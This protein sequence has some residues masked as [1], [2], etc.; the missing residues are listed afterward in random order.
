MAVLETARGGLLKRGLAFDR[1]GVGVVLNVSGDHLGLDGVETL[2]DLAHVKGL[3]ARCAAS[4]AVLNAED[5]WCVAMNESL[6]PG[7]ETIFFAIDPLHPVLASHLAGGGRAAYLDDGWLVW[8]DA[9]GR[10]ALVEAAR[11]P[12]TLGGRARYNVANA[13]AAVAALVAMH[14]DAVSSARALMSFTS[15]AVSNPFRS[16]VFEAAGVRLIVDYAHNVAAYRALCGMARSQLDTAAGRLVGVVTSPGDRRAGDLFEVGQVCG[17]YF[18]ELVV[19]E[20]DPRGR[21]PGETVEAILAGAR[22][23]AEGKPLHGVPAIRSA[24]ATGLRMSRPGDVLVF[25]CAGTLD[26]LVAGVREV[27][28]HAADR[29]SAA[30]AVKA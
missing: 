11:L 10:H 1:C 17:E 20:Q 9:A 24:L 6:R 26:D 5:P 22:T 3:V 15:D 4:A 12:V 27:D 28:A 25:T 30:I 21:A 16:N 29:I 14:Q 8:N 19:Y 18:D 13:L 23:A 2:A 7:C